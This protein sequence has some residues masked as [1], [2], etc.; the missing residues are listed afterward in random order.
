M[1][2]RWR[3]GSQNGNP[4]FNQQKCRLTSRGV[5]RL[6]PRRE[7]QGGDT[8]RLRKLALYSLCVS[9]GFLFGVSRNASAQQVFGSI[10]GTVTDYFQKTRRAEL[11]ASLKH[12]M[13]QRGMSAEE[14]K[15]VLEAS[16]AGTRSAA[17][18]ARSCHSRKDVE[19]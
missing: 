17:R 19:V 10:F 6:A 15:T 12:E 4:G 8:L 3:P 13:L 1:Y 5:R 18:S 9:V 16:S 2:N 14:I 7:A 11:D